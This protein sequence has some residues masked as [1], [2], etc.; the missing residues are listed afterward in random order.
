MKAPFPYFGG[1]STIAADVWKRFGHDVQ[2][3]VEPFAG[4]AAML[5]SRPHWTPKRNYIETIND[6]D[7]QVANFWRAVKHDAEA[8]AGWADWPVNENDLHARHGWL[9]GRAKG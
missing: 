5:L 7:G 2:N 6:A 9:V 4:S 1:K 3:Y 8:V